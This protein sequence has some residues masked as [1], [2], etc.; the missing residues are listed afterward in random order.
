M[1]QSIPDHNHYSEIYRTDADT[2]AAWLELGSGMKADSIQLLM[3]VSGDAP[4][5]MVELGCGTGAVIRECRR[6]GLARSY[7][8]V[9]YSPI[10]LERLRGEDPSIQTICADLTAQ[11]FALPQHADLLVCTHVVEHLEDPL[12]FLRGVRSL[13]FTSCVIEVP[14]E[15]LLVGRL[16][17]LVKD[18]RKNAAGHIQFF[19]A[20]SFERLLGTAG[21]HVTHRRTYVPPLDRAYLKFLKD[22][23]QWGRTRYGRAVITGLIAPR[24][25][26]PAWRRMYYAHHAVRCVKT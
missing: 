23:H 26:E 9:D 8:A 2:E 25:A 16:K 4:R 18:R 14:L 3:R 10:A 7:S 13:D 24:L 1:P 19:T 5:T 17:A 6:R 22:R 12:T 11:S 20:N 15:D 21:L